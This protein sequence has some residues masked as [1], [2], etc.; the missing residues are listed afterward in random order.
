MSRQLLYVC[1]AYKVPRVK[2]L[3]VR[4]TK[5][6]LVEKIARQNRNLVSPFL[7]PACPGVAAA[8]REFSTAD[9]KEGCAAARIRKNAAG[10]GPA[11]LYVGDGEHAE[12]LKGKNV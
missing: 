9:G 2:H 5:G 10:R 8:S 12:K 3:S 6:G 7:F 11:G 4:R 1:P